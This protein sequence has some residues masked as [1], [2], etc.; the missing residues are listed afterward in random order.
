MTRR[1]G[2]PRKTAEQKLR[3]AE[4]RQIMAIAFRLE[5]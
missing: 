3:V 2:R 5:G 4:M 1:K